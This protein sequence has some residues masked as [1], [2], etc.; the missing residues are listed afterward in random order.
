MPPQAC[1]GASST[2]TQ[3]SGNRSTIALAALV[4]SISGV[5][6]TASELHN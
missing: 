5:V 4:A 2:T 6:S 3:D 1:A